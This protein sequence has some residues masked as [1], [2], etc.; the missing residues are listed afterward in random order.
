MIS[1]EIVEKI[2]NERI[3]EYNRSPKRLEEDTGTEVNIAESEQGRYILELLQNADDAMSS[4]T[5]ASNSSL[6]DEIYF[7]ITEK[8]LYCANNGHPI[9]KEG[10]EAICSAFL[11]PK[12]KKRPVIGF[13]GIGFKSVLSFTNEPQIFWSGGGVFFSKEKTFEL[14]LVKAPDAIKT[15]KEEIPIL[16][17]P[18]IINYSY[19]IKNDSILSDLVDKYNTV[20]K[21]PL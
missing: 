12:R 3:D 8:Y 20:F 11:S 16:R 10:L 9:S 21:F 6:G 18:H 4:E 13:K 7:K 17:I 15:S 2:A 14:L 19:E 5:D 1:E